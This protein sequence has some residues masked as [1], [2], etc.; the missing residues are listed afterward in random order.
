V[1]LRLRFL[2]FA[3]PSRSAQLTAALLLALQPAATLRGQDAATPVFRVN[4]RIVV[5]DVVVTDKK[6][7]AVTGLKQSDF[8]VYEDKQPQTILTFEPPSA[9]VMPPSPDGHAIVNSSA[10]LPKIG[11]APITLLVLDELNTQFTDMSYARRS[12]EKYLLAQPE[13]LNQPTALLVANNTKFVL[14]QDYTQDRA[15]ILK[16]LRAHMPQYPYKAATNGGAAAVERIAQTMSSVIQIAEATRGTPGRKNVIWVGVNAPGVQLTAADPVTIKEMNDLTRRV[17]QTLL[18]DRVTLNYIDPT[19]NQVSTLA[20]TSSDDNDSLQFYD[21][22]PFSVDVDFNQF[23]PATGGKIFSSRNDINN[24]IATSID[25]GNSYYTLSYSPTNKVEDAAK[26]RGIHIKLSDPDLTATTREGYY[27]EAANAN[28]GVNDTSLPTA[29]RQKLL[30]LD[31]SQAATSTLAYNGLTFTAQKGTDPA[32]WQVSVP[33]RN[34]SWQQLPNGD[35][36]AEVTA[37][38]VAYDGKNKI[39]AHVIR[40]MQSTLKADDATPAT[41][42][43]PVPVELPGGTKRIRFIIRD[44]VSGHMG[45]ADVKP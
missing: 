22:D 4:T 30:E 41:V 14:L 8:S 20:V 33:G 40:E 29:Q 39:L 32:A 26:F 24:E 1:F 21:N 35:L 6:G 34:L 25:A 11:N 31:L 5:L 37:M 38:S 43:F 13:V 23:A 10:D 28:N 16:A 44:A 18:E 15:S 3:Q 12:L 17:T 2:R 36:Q 27:P 42:L 19:I 7:N 45:T 9:H